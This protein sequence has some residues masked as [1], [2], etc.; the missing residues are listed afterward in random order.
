MPKAPGKKKSGIQFNFLKA[1][2][3][4]K[5][6]I[7]HQH[8]HY[9]VS[10]GA[11]VSR[12]SASSSTIQTPVIQSG[13][14]LALTSPEAE[15]Y[16]ES[17]H[18]DL[19]L[20]IDT[21]TSS[22]NNPL[23]DI[24]IDEAYLAFLDGQSG[25]K[26]IIGLDGRSE[27]STDSCA[28]CKKECGEYECLDCFGR[29]M[30]CSKCITN[31]HTNLFLHHV[32][33]WNGNFF[34]KTSLKD[35]GLRVQ[36]GHVN[37][38]QC[39]KPEQAR[40]DDFVIIDTDAIHNVLLD[41]CG[42]GNITQQHTVQ[43]LR[44]RLFPATVTN[45]KS[46]ATF[47]SL[48]Y[49]EILSYESKLSVF[50]FYQ[51]ISRCTDN[52]GMDP[53]KDRYT[54]LL[55]M[56]HEWRHLKLMKRAGRGHAYG[57]IEATKDGE[58][59][60]LCPA[61]PQPGKNMT[62]R[63]WDRSQRFVNTLFVALDANF[64]LKRKHVS[65]IEADPGLNKGV[66]YFVEET[67]YKEHLKPYMEDKEPKCT[68]SRHNAYN[69]SEK[70]SGHGHAVTGIAACVCSRH[71]M[72][73]AGGIGDLQRGERYCNMDYVFHSAT[74]DA[75]VSSFVVSYDIACQWSI[76]IKE[77]MTTFDPTFFVNDPNVAVRYLVPKFHLP[78]HIAACRSNYSFNF[79]KETGR[80][81]GEAP[82]RGW[83][84]INGLAPSTREM[85]PGTRSDTLDSHMGDENW[86]KVI[87][88]G[89]S[90]LRK[91]KAA[92]KDA[93]D[94]VIAHMELTA[95]LP[96][97]TVARWTREVE[98]WEDD[99]NETN[100]YEVTIAGP[101]QA[102]VLKQLA[103]DEARDLEMSN[104]MS[105]DDSVTPSVLISLGI[106]L[107]S[108]QRRLK[109]SAKNV[110]EHALDRQCTK[111]QLNLNALQCKIDSWISYQQLYFPGVPKLR[112]NQVNPMTE[113]K[114]H[115]IVLWLPSQIKELLV[116]P[117]H[118]QRIEWKI[119]YS[120]AH[121]ALDVIQTQLQIRAHLYKFKD[122]FV[123][124]QGPNTKAKNTIAGVDKK[125]KVAVDD[126]HAAFDALTS[127]APLLSEYKWKEELLLLRPEDVRD[128]SD[129]KHSGK[130][131]ESEGKRT[132]SWIWKK[133]PV[134]DMNDEAFL[135]DRLRSEWCKSR[136][137]ADRF[138]EEVTLLSE[139]MRRVLL[140]FV[141]KASDWNEKAI[142]DNWQV[143]E[144]IPFQV[145][146]RIAYAKRQAD[147]YMRLKAHCEKL[148]LEIPAH[149]SRMRV[150]IAETTSVLQEAR[151]NDSL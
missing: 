8:I 46:A 110:W 84:Y 9:T 109:A 108:E 59:A 146:G 28:K 73:R 23:L 54:S 104:D 115:D 92:V 14:S 71:D 121:E 86:K 103:E 82:E 55:R 149:I 63:N 68:C 136:A 123:R 4:K 37:G 130:G 30:L 78:A 112:E 94:H 140:F 76:K 79:A 139:E 41:F 75:G 77:R 27:L 141:W 119:R 69:M 132:M 24:P 124:G 12:I 118:L 100:P 44:A 83:V 96:K 5:T 58:C 10:A 91:M 7:L 87:G 137:R 11:D 93:T 147:M 107:E 89:Q 26:E 80:T 19:D 43:L 45:P 106:D 122:R 52:T 32:Q 85:G 20:L 61:C 101:T 15:L 113:I 81:D 50:E 116:V 62:S 47:R 38:E 48:E 144:D 40:N 51:T 34:V 99:H 36:L 129:G 6:E 1:P 98:T 102:A 127:L 2:V 133:V 67:T 134:G 49:L 57:G 105:L 31:T 142:S 29:E 72:K 114:A 148:W 151:H 111:H 33:H 3:V 16:L 138:D 117:V 145:E 25:H 128:I 22:E 64:R 97:E 126:Y 13:D 70:K 74:K 143:I 88:M 35:L 125:I 53:P 39:L 21:Q 18:M 131:K 56:I 135:T 95:T 90:L 17:E 150:S 65:S 120:Q 60:V 66:A 42:C